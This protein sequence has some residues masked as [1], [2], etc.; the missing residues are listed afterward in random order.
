[1]IDGFIPISLPSVI[2]PIRDYDP[3]VYLRLPAKRSM[4]DIISEGRVRDRVSGLVINKG[5][6]AASPL[7][8]HAP[9]SLS[10]R[11]RGGHEYDTCEDAP[12]H[13]ANEVWARRRYGAGQRCCRSNPRTLQLRPRLVYVVACLQCPPPLSHRSGWITPENAA[14]E[15]ATMPTVTGP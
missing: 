12:H 6:Q 2:E 5:L 11:L 1:M 7:N 10:S 3:V 8:Q 13:A 9:G 15:V 14:S 4:K